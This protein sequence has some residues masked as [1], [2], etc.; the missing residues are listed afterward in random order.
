M[1][2][3]TRVLIA[4]VVGIAAGVGIANSGSPTLARAATAIEPLGTLWIN[5][6]RMT[7]IPRVVGSLIGGHPA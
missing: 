2:L 4:L 1:S 5:A 3:T 7:V 6:I